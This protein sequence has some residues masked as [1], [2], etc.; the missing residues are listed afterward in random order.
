MDFGLGGGLVVNHDHV[1]CSRLV[2]CQEMLI[3]CEK[4]W[5]KF[6]NWLRLGVLARAWVLAWDLLTC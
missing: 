5:I 1:S 6:G 4:T 3:F 2:K